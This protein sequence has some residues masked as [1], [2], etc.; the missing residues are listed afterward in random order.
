VADAPG[1]VCKWEGEGGI[2]DMAARMPSCKVRR[3]EGAA[4]SIHNTAPTEYMQ[5]LIDVIGDAARA[6]AAEDKA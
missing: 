2:D 4:H 1:T 5:A 3:F 6:A